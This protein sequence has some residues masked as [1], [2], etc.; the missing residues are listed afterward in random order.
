MEVA[1][2]A[3]ICAFLAFGVTALSGFWLV[4][5]LR[6]L[7]FG[8]TILDIGPSWH[9]NKEGTPTM[10]GLMFVAGI[11]LAGAVAFLFF[12]DRYAPEFIR[13]ASGL[14]MAVG[15][16]FLGFIDDYMKVVRHQNEGLTAKQKFIGQVLLAVVFLFGLSLT[17][18]L[19]TV[20]QIPFI[21]Q[22]DL[23]IFYYPLA[24]FIIVGTSNA[25][26][27]TDG[28]DGL[29]TSVTFVCACGFLVMAAILEHIGVTF[30]AAALAGGCLGFFLWNA[31]PAK[32]FMGDTGSLFLGGMVCAMAFALNYPVILLFAGIV[33][34]LETL[35][36]I[37][38][39]GCYKLTHKRVFKMAPIHHHFEMCGWSEWKIVF[40]FSLVGLLGAIV[41]I[42]AVRAI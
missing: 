35:S 10:G 21:G 14:L 20:L 33:Y 40:V 37:I 28:I 9:K 6:K 39:I 41:S 34:V 3:T 11:L 5:A 1:L 32:V 30:L 31:H 8:Q 25:V 23:G 18:T 36:D 4:P 42:L 13:L 38:Q 15:Y 29:C 26:N 16:G 12:K 2:E 24:V 19:S 22:I 7:K 27:L 17:R